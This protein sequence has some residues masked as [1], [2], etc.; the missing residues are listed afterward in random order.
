MLKERFK[1]TSNVHDITRST[2]QSFRWKRKYSSI[3]LHWCIGY[4]ADGPIVEFLKKAK[5]HLLKPKP[6]EGSNEA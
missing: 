4:D 3:F 1:H 5:K 6:K 2:F